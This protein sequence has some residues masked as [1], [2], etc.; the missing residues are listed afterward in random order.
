ME[1]SACPQ[2]FYNSSCRKPARSVHPFRHNT[3][4]RHRNGRTQHLS[5]FYRCTASR[6]KKNCQRA[7]Y[8]AE[9]GRMRR[10]RAAGRHDTCV[11]SAPNCDLA[12]KHVSSPHPANWKPTEAN[13]WLPECAQ[14][15]AMRRHV[16][17][18]P[19]N[20]ANCVTRR[21]RQIVSD[22][23]LRLKFDNLV[24]AKD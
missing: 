15:I 5:I 22:F 13:V 24:S 7:N 11:R 20:R 12:P 8:R 3:G 14:T 2:N 6:G 21:H 10:D 17:V 19:N 23:G 9:P 1:I 16:P 4:L 18:P